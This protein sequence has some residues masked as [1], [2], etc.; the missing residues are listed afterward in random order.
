MNFDHSFLSQDDTTE[1]SP[2][3]NQQRTFLADLDHNIISSQFVTPNPNT[4]A[5]AFANND[6]SFNEQ[7]NRF[8]AYD[9]FDLLDFDSNRDP[10][11]ETPKATI[12]ATFNKPLGGSNFSN[13]ATPATIPTN[14]FAPFYPTNENHSHSNVTIQ[15][16]ASPVVSNIMSSQ[17]F[18]TTDYPTEPMLN[19]PNSLMG[20]KSSPQ[21]FTPPS[22]APPQ[23]TPQSK[24]GPIGLGLNSDQI[25]ATPCQPPPPQRQLFQN[26]QRQ[27]PSQ[28]NFHVQPPLQLQPQ[29]N[30]ISPYEQANAMFQ[31]QLQQNEYAQLQ[32]DLAST[33]KFRSELS[34]NLQALIKEEKEKQDRVHAFQ[35][36][37]PKQR[38][39][40][41]RRSSAKTT[42]IK[43]ESG[44]LEASLTGN[45]TKDNSHSLS[46]QNLQSVTTSDDIDSPTTIE[47]TSPQ[48]S[49]DDLLNNS[50]TNAVLDSNNITAEEVL[51]DDHFK[52][53]VTPRLETREAFDDTVD[54]G[55]NVDI[56]FNDFEHNLSNVLPTTGSADLSK[57]KLKPESR[58]TSVNSTPKK[59]NPPASGS[60][61]N[62]K[63]VLK[64]SSSFS[65]SLSVLSFPKFQKAKTQLKTFPASQGG[66]SMGIF[67]VENT[68]SLA[69]PQKRSVSASRV[70]MASSMPIFTM[71]SHYS[72][73]YE[74]TEENKSQ[75]GS[76]STAASRDGASVSNQG[77]TGSRGA[78]HRRSLSG[79]RLSN[80]QEPKFNPNSQSKTFEFQV[81]LKK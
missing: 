22:H 32:N 79:R 49:I 54:F 13:N 80:F 12:N 29:T 71:G 78:N 20:V 47:V 3:I 42:D 18:S 4:N 63:K 39:A 34:L 35:A 60:K 24:L 25:Y 41:H 44:K 57:P 33:R 26:I 66:A 53:L 31:Q 36:E 17:N 30:N 74:L 55:H 40:K 11:L 52:D 76:G 51:N 65:D 72:F 2:M 1:V 68:G 38:I 75:D 62:N 46:C 6:F 15:T 10:C 56:N 7:S 69:S 70:D 16:Q 43:K 37:V 64:K 61:A 5:S 21:Q 48:S 77:T 28:L 58:S 81:D 59:K 50:N 23:I 8:T 27:S 67:A 19:T 14:T 45:G 9:F 73:I